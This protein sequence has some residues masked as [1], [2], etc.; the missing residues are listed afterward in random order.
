MVLIDQDTQECVHT[1]RRRVVHEL[2]QER[3][4]IVEVRIGPV[5]SVHH[6]REGSKVRLGFHGS[7]FRII[8]SMMQL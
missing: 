1:G 5:S 6:S 4:V 7:P 2:A 8:R 3:G